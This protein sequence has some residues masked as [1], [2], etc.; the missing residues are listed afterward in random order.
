LFCLH[1]FCRLAV[2][3]GGTDYQA[4]YDDQL[5]ITWIA[6]PT[7]SGTTGWSNQVAWA[8]G[9]NIGGVTDWRLASMDVNG[10]GSVVDCKTASQAACK[11][12]EYGHL[13]YY[14]AGSILFSGISKNN[15]APFGVLGFSGFFN[16]SN[17][18]SGT[19]SASDPLNAWTFSFNPS[20]GTFFQGTG[21]KDSNNLF[22]WAVKSGDVGAVPIPAAMWL[23]GSGV[24]ALVGVARRKTVRDGV[25]II[26]L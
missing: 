25:P 7:I 15:H 20:F 3:P 5:D 11:D 21:G 19:T 18:W 1:T 22:G 26:N 14:G 6:N 12:N 23:F 17:Y 9:L 4:Y 10:D 13:A 8:T 2:T 24:L 16:D